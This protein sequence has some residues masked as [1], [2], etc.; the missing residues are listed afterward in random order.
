MN[1]KFLVSIAFACLAFTACD[2]TTENIGT[3]LVEGNDGVSI[4]TAAFDVVSRSIAAD[5]VLS[6]NV[7]GYLGKV[8]DPETGA[9]IT[10]D[11]MAQFNNLENFSF[12]ALDSL[13]TYDSDGNQTF[14]SK[15]TIHADSCEIRLFIDGYY[16]DDKQSMKLTA[17][18]MGKTMNED[19]MYYSNFDPIS[20]GYIRNEGLKKDKVYNLVD[21]NVPEE[22]RDTN[23]YTPYITIK[24]DGEY[25]DKSA[26]TYSN[27]GSYVLQK[28]YDDPSNFKNA[29]TFRNNVVPGFFFK[30]KSG[31]GNMAKIKTSQLNVYFKN[32]VKIPYTDKS[33][34]TS[35]TAYK[36]TILNQVAV[37]WGTEEVLQTTT[38]TND[39]QTIGKL[40]ADESCT[41][42][43]T[44][45]GIFTELTLP[46][47]SILQGHETDT[48]VSARLALPRLNNN[49]TSEYA[50]DI[51]QNVLMVP[52]DSLYSF[53]EKNKLYDNKTTYA[54][55]WAYNGNTQSADNSYIFHNISGLISAMNNSK[56]KSENWNKV[57]LVPVAL[58]F[59]QTSSSAW[60]KPTTTVNKVSNDMSLTS[61]RLMRGTET[62][63]PIKISIIYSKIR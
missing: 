63:S 36:D 10:G 54:A 6:R 46:V 59:T 12:P 3:S 62:N 27:Y 18:E 44:P 60:S 33:G 52:K 13:V 37:F 58:S 39:K 32:R 14:G 21:Y 38:I 41:Y 9:Y 55:S 20:N 7:T 31:L 42:L 51:P 5:S 56:G 43:K 19:R 35:V 15:G 53:F 25:T 45:A 48:I 24:L 23:T 61:T 30:L 4:Q 8:R 17:Y 11:F 1:S 49:V 57:V 16:G 40:V 26:K 2:D 34:G 29:F 50:F 22:Q 28:Y 47:E